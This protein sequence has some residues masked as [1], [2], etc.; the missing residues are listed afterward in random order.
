[1]HNV[2]FFQPLPQPCIL[3]IISSLLLSPSFWLGFHAITVQTFSWWSIAIIF[4]S[5][6]YGFHLQYLQYVSFNC[7]YKQNRV[8]NSFLHNNS[9]HIV[10]SLSKEEWVLCVAYLVGMGRKPKFGSDLVFKNGTVHNFLYKLHAICHSNKNCIEAALG[11][12]LH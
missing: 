10:W 12:Y 11:P 8:T 5:H 4:V 2:S 9:F 6:N 7:Q 3:L 1:M